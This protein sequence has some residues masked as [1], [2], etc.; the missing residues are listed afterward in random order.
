MSDRA[1]LRH[2]A[3]LV[4]N[5]AATLGV[6]LQEAAIDGALRFDEISDAVL[7]CTECPNP[8]HCEA[9]LSQNVDIGR[10]PEYCR[11]QELLNR[12]AP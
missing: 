7:R 10:A 12:L 2:H 6:D 3:G 9:L 4:D 5:M 8:G 11:N 1:K